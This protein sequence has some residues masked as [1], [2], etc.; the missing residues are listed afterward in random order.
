MSAA[1][2]VSACRACGWRGFPERLWCPVCG[3]DEIDSVVEAA[4][5]VEDATSLRRV[6]GRTLEGPVSLGTVRSDGGARVVARL[7]AGPGDRVRLTVEEGA[8]VARRHDDRR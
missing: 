8:P 7:E 5:V 3:G 2:M 6:T 4:G 1:L